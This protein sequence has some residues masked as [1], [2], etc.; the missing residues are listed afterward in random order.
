MAVLAM[1]VGMSEAFSA[2][3]KFGKLS[4]GVKFTV[5]GKGAC[6]RT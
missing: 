4:A 3:A 1:V 5:P 2:A 6:A